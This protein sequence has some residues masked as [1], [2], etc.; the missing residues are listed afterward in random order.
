MGSNIYRNLCVANIFNGLVEGLSKFSKPSRVALIYQPA[1]E[2]ELKIY[3]PRNLLKGHEPKLKEIYYDDHDAWRQKTADLIESQPKG[4]LAPV[5]ELSLSGLISYGGSSAFFFYQMW[6]TDHHPN[7]CSTKPTE[8]WLE[9]ASWLL[10]A[11][12]FSEMNTS[13]SSAG[14][15]LKNYALQA[16]A[17]HIV[18]ERSKSM[19]FDSKLLIPPIL[20]TIL[21]ISKTREEGIAA[22]GRI[23]FTDPDRISHINF[24]TRIQKHEQPV[25]SNSKHIRKLL[26]AVEGSS[27][28]LVSDGKTIVGVTDDPVPAYA[29]ASEYKGDH[30]FLTLGEDKICSF[31]DGS[32]HST[33]REAK[34][35]ELEELLLDSHL[36]SETST[37]LFQIVSELVHNAERKRHGCTLIIDLNKEPLKMTG[38]VLDPPINLLDPNHIDLACSLT[39]VD[40]ALHITPD[41]FINGFGC[42]LDGAATSWEN[43][44]RGARYNSALRFSS[45]HENI[46]AVVVSSDR[47][48]SIIYCGIEINAYSV[49]EPLYGYMPKPV[50]LK[51]Y[52]N[53]VLK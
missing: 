5:N 39:K 23:V 28:K 51:R 7:M 24:I 22:Q 1:H 41:L 32:F 52:L 42:L 16:I 31:H 19:N 40:G 34:M 29:I 49:W 47:P 50:P 3:D 12:Y 44:A 15:T 6:F 25:L 53:G 26:L 27:R 30:G 38:H 21:D 33:T 4:Y 17:D 11:D 10:A 9:Q 2:D 35:V 18:D 36:E 13:G 46:I 37:I 43:L 48:V 20:N 8:K 45:E 14:Y